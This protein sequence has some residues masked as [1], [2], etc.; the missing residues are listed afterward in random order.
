M[1]EDTWEDDA[2]A[3][4]HKLACEIQKWE[5]D[6]F[7]G[8]ATSAHAPQPA[9]VTPC[10][11]TEH[12]PDLDTPPPIPN[13]LKKSQLAAAKRLEKELKMAKAEKKEGVEGTEKAKGKKAERDNKKPGKGKKDKKSKKQ[14]HET[15]KKTK[16]AANGPMTEAMKEFVQARR[17]EGVSYRDAMK[18]W[19]TSTERAS[20]VDSL[21]PSEQKRRRYT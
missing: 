20:I 8:N 6:A 9:D 4:D 15:G 13:P 10:R 11:L 16:N 17:G 19:R 2:V 12:F 3:K 21:S 5:T 1:E 7:H 14:K 18:Q